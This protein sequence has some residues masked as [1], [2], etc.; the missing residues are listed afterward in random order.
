MI[1][2]L[3]FLGWCAASVLAVLGAAVSFA[4]ASLRVVRSRG[5]AGPASA[6]VRAG[7]CALDEAPRRPER[8]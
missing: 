8:A 2:P 3:I 1:I 4:V 5:D 7:D 6:V